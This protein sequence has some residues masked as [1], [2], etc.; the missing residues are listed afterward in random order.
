MTTRT[1]LTLAIAVPPAAYGIV[2]LFGWFVASHACPGTAQPWSLVAVR[3]MVVIATVLALAT[4]IPG[5][6]AGARAFGRANGDAERTTYL[7]MFAVLVGA[8]MT[9]GLLWSAL[10]VLILKSCGE[11]R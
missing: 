6:A 7:S 10:S 4:S 3:W 5:I 9:F 2:E 8:T 1:R 11:V